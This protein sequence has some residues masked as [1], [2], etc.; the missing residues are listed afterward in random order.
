ML[1]I[2][3]TSKMPINRPIYRQS[4]VEN[5]ELEKQ[6]QLL[7]K[8]GIIEEGTSPYNNNNIVAVKKSNG[9]IRLVNDFSAL[10]EIMVPLTFPIM[11]ASTL[12]D[13]LAESQ[14]FSV[15][16]MSSGF[17]QCRLHPNSRKFTAYSTQG[18]H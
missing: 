11:M 6:N 17:W 4:Q 3:L 5:D 14:I 8:A 15:T 10:N 2:E 12:F 16:D 18:G 13:M 7:F 1:E 9:K